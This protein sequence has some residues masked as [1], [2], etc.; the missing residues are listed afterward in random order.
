MN[1]RS[2]F[3]RRPS[4][5]SLLTTVFVALT[6]ILATGLTLVAS[7]PAQAAGLVVT[8][9][10]DDTT[11]GNG[12]SLREALGNAN[13][14]AATFPDCPA[15]TG[16]DTITFNLGGPATISTASELAYT[17]IDTTTIDGAGLVT[18]H[19][20]VIDSVLRDRDL[21]G[22]GREPHAGRTYRH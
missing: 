22:G 10:A 5:P 8:T 4:R 20:T 3:A 18:L 16:A 9:T 13:D 14:D 1:T 12:C 17:D 2:T 6:T 21:S 7:A 19:G 11:T 15:G